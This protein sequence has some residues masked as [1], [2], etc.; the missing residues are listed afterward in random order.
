[1]NSRLVASRSLVILGAA[2]AVS[3]I[4]VPLIYDRL[5][6]AFGVARADSLWEHSRVG[7]LI[8]AGFVVLAGA[9]LALA[10]GCYKTLTGTGL[11]LLAACAV[12]LSYDQFISSAAVFSPYG[13]LPPFLAGLT[14]LGAGMVATRTSGATFSVRFIMLFVA[15]CAATLWVARD[16][17]RHQVERVVTL[18]RSGDED[19]CP[20]HDEQLLPET[21]AAYTHISFV[22]GYYEAREELFP[23]AHTGDSTYTM[24]MKVKVRYCPRCRDAQ[25]EWRRRSKSDDG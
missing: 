5:G 3:T 18:D 16:L 8:G 2:C 24:H 14:L 4:F 9:A 23:Y 10:P 12:G 7:A 25:E 15:G 21:Q 20:L 11:F 17:T 19:V 22:S 6:V 1:M 13:L